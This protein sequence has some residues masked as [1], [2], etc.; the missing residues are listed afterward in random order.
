MQIS[1]SKQRHGKPSVSAHA[2]FSKISTSETHTEHLFIWLQLTIMQISLWISR[3]PYF[4]SIP[5]QKS[6]YKYHKFWNLQFPS[7]Y[8]PETK[9]TFVGPNGEAAPPSHH[10]GPP[11]T[12]HLELQN[13]KSRAMHRH[14]TRLYLPERR[15]HDA[16]AEAIFFGAKQNSQGFGMVKFCF[17]KKM[18]PT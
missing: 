14:A 8:Y 2:P 10:V 6:T 18:Y 16:T 5:L 12:L 1:P 11:K 4:V 13:S 17:V 3:Y 9:T 15:N 7:F